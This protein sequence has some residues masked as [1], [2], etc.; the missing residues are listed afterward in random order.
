MKHRFIPLMLLLSAVI[1]SGCGIDTASKYDLYIFNTKGESAD[2]MSAAAKAYGDETGK[3]IKVFS[4]GSGT[5]S[6]D[7]LR[8][9]M[10]SKNKPGIFSIMNISELAEWEEGGFALDLSGVT[11]EKFKA[12]HDSIPSNMRLTSNG[13]GSYGIPY[14]VEGYG[15]ITDARMIAA[16]FGEENKDSV[17]NDLKYCDYGEFENFVTTLDNYI[18]T[19][20]VSDVV[21]NENKYTFASAKNELSSKLNGVFAVAGSEKWTYGDHM[22]NVALNAVFETPADALAASSQ[23]L[24]NLKN[25]FIAYAKALDL[26]TSHAAGI[27]G[28][29]ARGAEFINSTTNNYDSAVQ[30]FAEGKALFLKQ[31][32]WVYTNIKKAN[33]EISDTLTFI[34]VKLPLSQN[35][36]K[37]KGLTVEKMNRSIPVFVPNYYA[38]NAKADEAQQ[39]EAL[40]FLVW[41]NTTDT[42]KK[43]ITEDMAFIPYNAS[44]DLTHLTNSL[45]NSILQYMHDGDILSNPYAGAP[46]NWSTDVLG[47]EIMEKYLTK[48]DWTADDYTTIAEYG[49]S[50]WKEMRPSAQ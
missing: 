36:I 21:L 35:D 26:K 38:V 34:P 16:V 39:K 25:P 45:G 1:L 33:S 31:G 2:A 27:N 14:N 9:E 19:N 4:L 41:L 50:K 46:I 13:I 30:A 32:N 42:G 24:D 17:L 7:T 48:P 22:I 18:K 37:V 23:D 49:I 44:P 15:Y 40:N 3:K 6:S 10:N 8:A 28:A 20:V 11:D 43:F 5:N 47:L 29:A 12:L